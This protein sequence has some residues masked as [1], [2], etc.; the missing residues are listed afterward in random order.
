MRPETATKPTTRLGQELRTTV[1]PAFGQES[2]MLGIFIPGPDLSKSGADAWAKSQVDPIEKARRKARKIEKNLTS[3]GKRPSDFDTRA[4]STTTGLFTAGGTTS[5]KKRTA[6]PDHS[7]RS[8]P[9]TTTRAAS[10]RVPT[11]NA[12][13]STTMDRPVGTQSLIWSSHRANRYPIHQWSRN[14]NP[15]AGVVCGIDEHIQTWAMAVADHAV[16]RLQPGDREQ[17][18]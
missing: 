8:A 12:G 16:C 9:A 11:W 2:R 5:T 10:P 17:A 1:A 7:K 15:A 6:H 3:V 18:Q 4:P 13:D 14:P